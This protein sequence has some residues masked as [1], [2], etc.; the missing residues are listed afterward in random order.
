MVNYL[1]VAQGRK[2]RRK[3]ELIPILL[4]SEIKK[5]ID[6]SE[7]PRDQCLVALLFC[8]GRRINEV[9]ELQ[10]QDF[11]LV[12]NLLSFATFNEKSFRK[13]RKS[14]FVIE[15]YVKRKTFKGRKSTPYEGLLYYEEI[16]PSLDLESDMGNLLGNYITNYLDA[17]QDGDYLFPPKKRGVGFI[18]QPQ[19]YNILRSLD[20]RLWLHAMRHINFTRMARVLRDNPYDL[21]TMTFHKQFKSTMEYIQRE[22]VREKLKKL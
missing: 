16:R 5:I 22:D 4:P 20:D 2:V 3:K 13:E 11:E 17:L 19:A 14:P 7:D 6:K 10:R 18:H 15:R 12:N 1:T 21:H 9:L 8:Y